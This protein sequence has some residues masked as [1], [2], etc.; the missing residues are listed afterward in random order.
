VPR[1]PALALAALLLVVVGVLVAWRL[2]SSGTAFEE[3][4]ALAPEG[5]DRVSWTDWAAV[6]RELGADL[7]ADSSGEDVQAFLDEAFTRDLSSSSALGSSA[8][9]LQEELGVSPATIDWELLAQSEAGAVEVLRLGPDVD[10]EEVGDR[11]E[12]LGWQR[13]EDDEGVWQGGPDVL[14]GVDAGL[15]PELQHV[16]LLADDGLLVSS[17]QAGY[18][19]TAVEAVR[20]DAPRVEGLDD[21]AAELADPLAAVVYTGAHACE[22][23]AMAQAD[24]DARAEADQLVEAAGGV[25]PLTAF[26]MGVV[27]GDAV[28]VALEVEDADDAEADAEAR[29]QLAAGPAPGQGGDFTE[30]FEVAGASAQGG[31]VTLDLRPLEGQ[32][33]LSDLSNGPVLFATC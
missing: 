23:L 16:A 20:G 15:T 11:L 4:V 18:L 7:D 32:Y 29:A 19:E 30:R 28:R 33:V 5:T 9:V 26:A 24:D 1:R 3:A 8:A 22:S 21:V 12:R 13:P 27:E 25:H 17:D 10:V 2:V 6:R 14:A 31:V